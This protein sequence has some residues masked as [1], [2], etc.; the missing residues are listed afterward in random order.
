M[1]R[2]LSAIAAA[3]A[4]AS[5]AFAY[6]LN[7]GGTNYGTFQGRI[8][9][10]TILTAEDNG[11]DPSTGTSYSLMG[12]YITPAWNGFQARAAAY[13][14]GDLFGLTDFDV[15]TNTGRVARGMFVAD[16]G[17]DK[18]QLTEINATYKGERIYAFAGRA[19]LDTPLT[20]ITYNHVPNSYTAFRIGATPIDALDISLGQITELSFGSRAMTD[21]GLI[22]EGTGTGGASQQP[23]QP[24]LGQVR[25]LDTGEMALGPNVRTSS[26]ITAASIAYEGLPNTK[27]Q[28]WNYYHEDISNDLYFEASGQIPLS[29]M[30]LDLGFQW[31]N[32]RDVGDG[33]IGI[34]GPVAVRS[35]FG[36]GDLEFD[37]I[38][39]KAGLVSKKWTLHAMY[40]HSS[41]DT[42]FLSAYGGDPAYTSTLF[43]RNAYRKDVDAWGVKATYKIMPGLVFA[44]QYADYGKSDTLGIIPNFTQAARPTSDA[45]ELDLILTWKPKQVKGLMLRTFYVYRTSEYDDFVRPDGR[46][47]DANMSH[48]RLVAAYNF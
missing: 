8:L 47:A 39:L 41:G 31:L 9:A 37:M 24:G 23:N 10:M 43:S 3:M 4:A 5:G 11:W 21:W 33:T 36:G 27:L 2:Q 29:E 48:W 40:N 42:A 25:F 1:L 19:P 35:N 38:G 32:Q 14:N 26:G 28:L 15:N 20:T 34:R 16:E 22:G 44:A 45:T 46:K 12:R 30:K 6:D 17:V 18:G 7:F 13:L